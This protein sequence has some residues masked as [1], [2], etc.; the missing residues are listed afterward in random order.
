MGDNRVI[1]RPGTYRMLGGLDAE[2]VEVRNQYAI[3]F[4]GD[5]PETWNAA[6]GKCLRPNDNGQSDIATD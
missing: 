3:G 4:V 6:T 5:F 1:Q 2:V